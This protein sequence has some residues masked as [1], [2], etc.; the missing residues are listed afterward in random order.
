NL[1]R[2]IIVGG[3][4]HDIGDGD[5]A[6]DL[7]FGDNVN[8]NRRPGDITSL[9]F[10]TLA[11]TP[12]Y[13]RTDQPRPT[14][15]ATPNPHPRGPPP[16]DGTARNYRDP[17]GAPW[18]AEYTIDYHLWNN[19]SVDQG[20]TG[21]G[22]FGNDYLAGS[23]GNDVILAQLG[24]DVVQGDGGIEGAFAATAHVGASRT[25]GGDTDPIGPLT[26]VASVERA[27]DGEDYVEGGG[28]NDVIFGGLGQDDLVG[29][30]SGFFSL[31]TPDLRPDGDDIIFGGAG[32]QIDRNDEDL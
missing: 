13:S 29:G 18:W 31:T 10:Q 11:G 21:A 23:E 24:N 25:S 22:S 4:G 30:S 27:S 6:D 16:T 12:L 26:V 9:H 32:T 14:G 20:L 17:D 8:L 5:E 28:G 7:V 3:A 19:F 1:G 2:D 15:F